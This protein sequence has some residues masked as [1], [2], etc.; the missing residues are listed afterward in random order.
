MVGNVYVP[1]PTVP[2]SEMELKEFET[3]IGATIPRTYRQFLVVFGAT[4]MPECPKIRCIEDDEGEPVLEE[5]SKLYGGK[6]E[7]DR[8][9]LWNSLEMYRGRVPGD[10]IPIGENSGGIQFCIAVRGPSRGKIF[11]YDEQGGDLVYLAADS[12][13]DFIERLQIGL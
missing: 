12:F 1:T 9:N 6:S 7:G 8:P 5:L 11:L 10:T 3:S 13:E 2:V 4:Y